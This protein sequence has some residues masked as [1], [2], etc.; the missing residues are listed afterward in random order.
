[1]SRIAHAP[2]ILAAAAVCAVL[3]ACSDPAPPQKTAEQLAPPA[4]PEVP[5]Q[6][7]APAQ[8]ALAPA[9]TLAGPDDP[10]AK[11]INEA[12]FGAEATTAAPAGQAAAKPAGPDPVMVRAQ[13][14]L[15]RARFAPGVIDGRGGENVRRAIAAYEAAHDLPADGMLDAEVWKA[16]TQDAAP[17]VVRHTLTAEEVAGPFIGAVPDGYEA[18]S[19]LPEL[20]YADVAEA[21]GETFHMDP[22]LLKALNP[23]ADFAAGTT[24]LVAAPRT[25]DLPEV[26][27]IEVDKG[28]RAVRAY[29]ASGAMVALYPASVGSAERPAPSGTWAVN[30]VAPKPVYYYDPRRL[31]FGREE[32]KGKLK[33][34]AGPNNPVGST[35]IDL[36]KDT[37]GIHGSPDPE[38]IGKR[39]SHG[40]VRLTNWD[41]AELGKAVKKGASVVFVGEEAPKK[42]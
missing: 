30:T 9:P 41:A 19:K 22:R 42:G 3:A 27:R 6:V 15:D 38:I 10:A 33:I 5:P 2:P 18:Q 31:T 28:A 17:A 40:C 37:Y 11:A 24:I 8:V 4:R 12:E 14:L 32:A 1:L 13:V 25:G 36:T 20:G 35:W 39:Q 21:L 16:L 29:D 7:T 23:E 26:A 34:A